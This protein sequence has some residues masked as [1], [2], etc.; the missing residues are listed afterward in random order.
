MFK[1]VQ[2]TKRDITSAISISCCA[3]ARITGEMLCFTEINYYLLYNVCKKIT[4][5][6]SLGLDKCLTF[7]II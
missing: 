3:T 7:S 4:N 5:T 1:L 2:N 6:P